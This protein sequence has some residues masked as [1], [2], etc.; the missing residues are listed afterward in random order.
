M[1]RCLPSGLPGAPPR[2]QHAPCQPHAHLRSGR[3][4]LAFRVPRAA[5][6]LRRDVQLAAAT[7][8]RPG[9]EVQEQQQ[10][11]EAE[12]EEPPA[13]Q[14]APASNGVASGEMSMETPDKRALYERFFQLLSQDLSPR[15]EVGD[16]VV[17]RVLRWAAGAGRAA[18]R[19]PRSGLLSVAAPAVWTPRARMW[20][21]T[22]KPLPTARQGS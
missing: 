12:E 13:A 7:V 18:R 17:G 3:C 1:Q 14:A 16:R 9:T 19:T 6:R 11:Q 5:R 2:A 10:L 8:D 15:Y 22:K 4:S 21:S 20:S